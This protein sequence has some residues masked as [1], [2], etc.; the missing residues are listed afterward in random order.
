MTPVGI[1]IVL[2]G[3]AAAYQLAIRGPAALAAGVA[4]VAAAVL[5][6]LTVR[7]GKALVAHSTTQRSD[8]W[9]RST[10]QER[11]ILARSLR[12]TM[13]MTTLTSLFPKQVVTGY[14][15]ANRMGIA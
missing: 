10:R 6:L 12:L 5:R 9:A 7:A 13:G 1:V 2:I 8:P 11:R 4:I 15:L 14:A 3:I